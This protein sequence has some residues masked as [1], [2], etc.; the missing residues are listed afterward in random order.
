MTTVRFRSTASFD[1]RRRQKAPA[2]DRATFVVF[3]LGGQHFAAPTES[4]EHV[5]RGTGDAGCAHYARTAIP[6]VDVTARLAVPAV[7][8]ESADARTLVLAVPGGWLAIVVD[9]VH[10]VVAID[11]GRIRRIPDETDGWWFATQGMVSWPTAAQG[12]LTRNGR[13]VVIL[14]ILRLTE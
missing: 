9:A 12:L 6:L 13:D 2:V 8:A 5:L 3:T 4:V 10:E 14:D 1:T 7:S 11:V